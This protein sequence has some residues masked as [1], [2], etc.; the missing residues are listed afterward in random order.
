MIYLDNAATSHPKPEPVYRRMDRVARE[1]GANPGRS[2][3]RLAVEAEREI[4]DA[5]REVASLLGARDPSRIVFTLNATDALS[6]AFHGLLQDKDHVV[7]THLEH[8]S[9]AR[10][11]NRLEAE[12]RIRVTRVATSG[13]GEL[14]P[15]DV[16][17]ALES[18]TRLVVVAHAGN[19]L[20]N[21]QPVAAICERLRSRGVLLLVDAAQSA[22]SVPIDVERD[23][24]DLLAFAGHKSLLGP[25]GTGGLWVGERAML[26]PWRE[27]GTGGD[28]A[29]PLQPEDLPHRLEAGTPNTAGIAGLGEAARWLKEKRVEEVAR[30]E[31]GLA[32]RL[33]ERLADA[34]AVDLYGVPP[35]TGARTGIVTFNVKGHAAG[36][37]GAI[38]D[39]SFGIAVRAG[40][41][42]APGVHRFIG[43]FP[44]GAVRVSP[45]PFSTEQDVD[46][47]AE[48]VREIAA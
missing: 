9:V 23:G 12:G 7:T 27:G 19:V 15:D 38:L 25:V 2:G 17:R 18:R 48:A 47:L 45:G 14:D 16:Q 43:T 34:G 29:S 40:L 30:H 31:A 41:H 21:V 4:A 6:M 5:R 1:V 10:P 44:E 11:L 37:V 33:W 28:S 46:T 20:G 22:G 36:E 26:R 35:G 42:C 3:H 13:S 24:I 8:N 32:R 39:A